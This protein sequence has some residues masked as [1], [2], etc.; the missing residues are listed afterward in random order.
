MNPFHAARARRSRFLF[1][2]AFPLLLIAC[3]GGGG[4]GDPPGSSSPSP[5][6]PGTVGAAGG[7]VTGPAGSQVVIPAGA[8]G[9]NVVISI[10]Q[11]SAGA[12]ALPGDV[13]AI[14]PMFAFEPHGTTFGS[15]ATVTIPFDPALLP[16]GGTVTLYKT[17]SGQA[18]WE[19]VPGSTV[20]TSSIS[21]PV[22]SF[23]YLVAGTPRPAIQATDA[24][25]RWFEFKKV[26]ASH[27]EER[28]QGNI[29][30][31]RH[32][33]PE[34]AGDMLKT[35]VFGGL[36]LF[37]PGRDDTASG[38]IFGTANG[39]T[40]WAEAE[41]PVA[42]DRFASP[43][44]TA[45]GA[46][47]AFVQKQSYRKDDPSASLHLTITQAFITAFDFNGPDPVYAGCPGDEASVFCRDALDAQVEMHVLVVSGAQG[48][49]SI[50]RFVHHWSNG[51]MV[52][53]G[54]E[55][56]WFENVYFSSQA[57]RADWDEYHEFVNPEALPKGHPIWKRSQ[58][59]LT[60]PNPND[61]SV[62]FALNEPLRFPVN[63]EAVPN[64]A[65]FTLDV[66]IYVRVNNRRARESYLLA[67][68][69]DPVNTGGVAMEYSNLTPT[70]RPVLPPITLGDPP[71]FEPC[72]GGEDPEAGTLQFSATSYQL[73]E[74]DARAHLVSVIRTGGTRGAV[75]ALVRTSNG[76]GTAGTH[77]SEVAQ[78][79]EFG[80]G[81]D[82]PRVV[83]V[84]VIDNNTEDGN[85]TVNL[86]LTAEPDCARIGEPVTAVLTIIDDEYVPP[87]PG[88]SGEL[89]ESF[90]GDGLQ[91]TAPFGGKGSRMV[92]QP[93]GKF[94]IVGGTFTHFIAARFNADGSPDTSF[95]SAGRVTTDVTG[96]SRIQYAR[97][98][99]V[100][101][102]G[103][104]VLAGDATL[105]NN[106]TAIA[107]VR[108][109]A[110]GS[111][112]SS[113][114]GDGIVH[115]AAVAGH[116]Y[117]VAIPPDGKIVVAGDAP[118]SGNASDLGDMLVARFESTGTLDSSF[119]SAGSITF[120][121]TTGTDL[122]RNL[123]LLP[124]GSMVVAG[125]AIGSDPDLQTGV[126]K[127]TA[128]GALDSSFGTGGRL[129][130]L[131]A[132]VGHGLALQPDG[133]LLLAGG[134][135]SF[136]SSFALM[137]LEADG[138]ADASFGNG[139]AVTHRTSTSTTG[140]GDIAY[141][142][143]LRPDGRIY[144]AG[145]SGSINEDFGLVRFTAAGV[146]DTTFGTNGTSVVDFDGLNDGAE[147][148]VVQPDGKIVL[149]GYATPTSTDGY[150]L[151]RVHP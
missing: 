142:I 1:L 43:D 150:G 93:D 129:S 31:L 85:V 28:T 57:W 115:E 7:T 27:R 54:F 67:R 144:V 21:A 147:N 131:A 89:D 102:D 90:D 123:V 10:S 65:E 42:E 36:S 15:P 16:A 151:A 127:L 53:K 22:G 88:P 24:P 81:D 92:M 143:A 87:E 101:P 56:H 72:S 108:Y 12:P 112:D 103:R 139:G 145:K 14:G 96:A 105:A 34:P 80:D 5:L 95:G 8:L 136:P 128:S 117:A 20:N 76:S 70:N 84:P 138:S 49:G 132:N 69:R 137:R 17:T 13:I 75:R 62:T 45:T 86:A 79:V 146:V 98:V 110:D 25:W 107:L 134:T 104:I 113:F 46:K 11:T 50:T 32:A 135:T 121:V 47:A 52:L 61:R 58:F 74:F 82:V 130:I 118:V 68:L 125:E 73:R 30:D 44:T 111:L 97:A 114:G 2:L 60:P 35:E 37:P 23:S 120:D 29:E 148:V 26:L 19:T 106:T 77:Y 55:D 66:R 33:Q 39:R 41:A 99:A 64:G 51:I 71:I 122:A 91:I 141:A 4:D 40:Y 119:G 100:Q 6:P 38:E 48:D 140:T 126:A 83:G 124:D 116:A 9:Q 109:L 18:S 94:L 78:I 133:K 59:T 3:G 63:I 149:G